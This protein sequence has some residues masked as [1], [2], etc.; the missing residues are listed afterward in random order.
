MENSEN[1]DEKMSNH[2]NNLLLDNNIE[3]TTDR[4]RELKHSKKIRES[5]YEILDIKKSYSRLSKQRIEDMCISRCPF[6][7]LHYKDIFYK[8]LREEIDISLLFKFINILEKIEIGN[9]NQHEASYQ[10]GTILKTIYIDS[11]LK[12]NK[13]LNKN[14]KKNEKKKDK[15]LEKK[16]SLEDWLNKKK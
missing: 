10:V 4:I 15:K 8:V 5:V 16:I 13:K 6:F 2:L 14:E 3:Q 11:V 7:L 12:R 1:I 9:L